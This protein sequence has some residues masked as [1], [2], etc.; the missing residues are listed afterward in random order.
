MDEKLELAEQLYKK[1]YNC[2]QAVFA[3]FAACRRYVAHFRQQHQ[4][5]VIITVAGAWT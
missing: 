3:V 5:S 4:F 2:S 1:G